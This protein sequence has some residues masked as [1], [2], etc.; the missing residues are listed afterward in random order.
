MGR[1]QVVSGLFRYSVLAAICLFRVLGLT[2]WA[3]ASGQNPP[4]TWIGVDEP[5]KLGQSMACR[6]FCRPPRQQEAQQVRGVRFP[7][8]SVESRPFYPFSSSLDSFAPPSVSSLATG[9]HSVRFTFVFIFV[10]S[11]SGSLLSFWTF[12]VLSVFLSFCFSTLFYFC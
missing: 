7:P 10:C 12:P 11:P 1:P 5:L 2:D 9:H 6:H 8:R 4:R 3:L